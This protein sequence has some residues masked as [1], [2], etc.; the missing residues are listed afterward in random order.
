M[1]TADRKKLTK[2]VV[3]AT[4]PDAA[5]DV[6]VWDTEVAGFRLRVRPSGRKAYE[7][8]YRARG[9][10]TQRQISIGRH[11]SPW[12]VEEARER[13]KTILHEAGGG[14]DPL[15]TRQ[16]ARLALTVAELADAYLLQGPAHKPNKRA[17]SW[18]VDTYNFSHHLKPLLG[19]RVARDL[20]SAHLAE[21]QSKVAAGATAKREKSGKLRGVT[22]VRGGPGAAARAM[23]SVAAMLAWARTQQ[24]IPANPAD[25]VEKIPDGQRERYLSDEEGASIWAAIDTLSDIGKL[26][27]RQVAYFRLLMLTGARRGEILGLRWA[28]IDFRRS[29]LL[30]APSRHKSGGRAR[31]KTLH[32]SAAALDILTRL[33][34]TRDGFTHV[35]PALAAPAKAGNKDGEKRPAIYRDQP[36]APPKAAWD[37]VLKAAGVSD[38]SFHVL[39]HTF[40]SQ[41]VADGTGL[42]TL[43]RM[44]GHARASTTERYAHLRADAGAAAAQTVADRYRKPKPAETQDVEEVA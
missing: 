5:G 4:L 7:L 1:S 29:M 2:R 9:S 11:G 18:A 15:A 37:R 25:N 24:L 32:L 43:S 35:F 28:E 42:Y 13:A 38:A 30:L 12:T 33:K 40:A 21:W 3:D 31:A 34:A 20:T 39:R 8:R 41:I 19:Q 27:D 14:V 44:L 6:I 16:E 17:T 26:T 22:H 23:R 10:T 36:M